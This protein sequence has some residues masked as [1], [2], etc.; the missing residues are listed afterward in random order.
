M[1][2]SLKHICKLSKLKVFTYKHCVFPRSDL[3]NIDWIFFA[4]H[5]HSWSSQTWSGRLRLYIRT[6]NSKTWPLVF[7]SRSTRTCPS[8]SRH[9]RTS[10]PDLTLIEPTLILCLSE[11][12]P[13]IL[14]RPG[15]CC[16]GSY[17]LGLYLPGPCLSGIWTFWPS[18]SLKGGRN[19]L[20]KTKSFFSFRGQ[21]HQHFMSAFA[22]ISFCQ[23]KIKPKI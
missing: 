22:L 3:A 1:V 7:L 20:L 11:Y 13:H 18:P 14:G 10:F 16:P 15:L 19:T 2:Y 9:S 6:L 8:L 4:W 5:S 12:D 23:K 21:F 17:R